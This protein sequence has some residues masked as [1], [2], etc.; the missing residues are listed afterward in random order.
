MSRAGGAAGYKEIRV[1]N[2][3]TGHAIYAEGESRTYNT[4][5]YIDDVPSQQ[6]VLDYLMDKS[7]AATIPVSGTTE[8]NGTV[9]VEKLWGQ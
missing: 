5:I 2:S 7:Q 1:D 4:V 3:I 8:P 9:V 6:G